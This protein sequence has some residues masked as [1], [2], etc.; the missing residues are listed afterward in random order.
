MPEG[1]AL[2]RVGAER[3][4]VLMA[5][6]AVGGVWTYAVELAR[7]LAELG[8]RTTIAVLG[9][10]PDAEARREAE[11]IPQTEIVETGQALDWTAG[12]ER[13][14]R[15]ASHALA[16]LA[17]GI[18]AAMVHLN[19]PALG[20][21]EYPVPVVAVAHSCVAT[22]WRAVRGGAL[23][24]D[25]IWRRRS[26]GQGM[27]KAAALIAPSRSFANA[28]RSV[29]GADLDPIVIPNGRTPP[30]TLQIAKQRCVLTAGRLWDEGKN[31]RTLDQAAA[32]L[33]A[34][35]LAAGA[36]TGPH[37]A[38]AQFDHIQPLGPLGRGALAERYAAAPVF[39]SVALYE[40]FGLAVLEAAQAGAALVLS[41]IPTFRELW[42]GAALFVPAEDSGALAVALQGLLDHP[43]EARRLAAA[44]RY[45]ARRYGA[46]A[47]A[48]KV[49]EVYE[50]VLGQPAR[51][52]G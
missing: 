17:A 7:G 39:A 30:P 22:W 31:L 29:Y 41:D 40:P 43:D 51:Q 25:F 12:D 6:D 1:L 2:G 46:R 10:A 13:E 18:G 52:A 37:G 47:M 32:R 35:V 3:R 9:P 49:A 8:F 45:R 11:E 42:N 28:L 16:G 5:A 14:L 44:A 26:A 33:D 38:A 34:P 4:H 36:L 20:A 19:A 21:V 50:A 24:A 27:R 48:Q 23:P 15:A